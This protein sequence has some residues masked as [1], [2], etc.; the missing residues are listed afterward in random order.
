VK[1]GRSGG[2]GD[3]LPSLS[4][5]MD[6][7][8]RASSSP[9]CVRPDGLSDPETYF[10]SP[11]HLHIDQLKMFAILRPGSPRFTAGGNL[12]RHERG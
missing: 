4:G 3:V 11:R 7:Y 5:H 8:K 2:R 10:P 9:Q 6:A 12:G 1:G